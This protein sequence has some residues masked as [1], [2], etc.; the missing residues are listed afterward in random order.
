MPDRDIV[1]T[2]AFMR[3]IIRAVYSPKGMTNS[4]KLPPVS[5]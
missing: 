2:L 3:E 1:L 4:P 5:G